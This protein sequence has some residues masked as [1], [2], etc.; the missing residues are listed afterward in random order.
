M[1]IKGRIEVIL[2]DN[3]LKWQMVSKFLI[4]FR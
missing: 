3:W 4:V 2:K 1:E